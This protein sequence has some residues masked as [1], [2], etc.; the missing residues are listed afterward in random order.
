MELDS[1]QKRYM[2]DSVYLWNLYQPECNS[3]KVSQ[4]S[5]AHLES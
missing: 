2:G 1:I 3:I 4:Q 5:S